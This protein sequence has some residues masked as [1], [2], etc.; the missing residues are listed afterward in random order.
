MKNTERPDWSNPIATLDDF[1]DQAVRIEQPFREFP[2]TEGRLH[3]VLGGT[4]MGKT[5]LLNVLPK[6][7]RLR[8]QAR[9]GQ[10]LV[11]TLIDYDASDLES[12]RAFLLRV[13]KRLREGLRE[14]GLCT[15]AE[16][17]FEPYFGD[18]PPADGFHEALK[19][20]LDQ[21]RQ[22]S[23]TKGRPLRDVR[24]VGL[25]DNAD[26]IAR[27]PWAFDLFYGLRD[28]YARKELVRHCLDLVLAGENWLARHFKNGAPWADGGCLFLCPMTPEAISVW[29][30]DASG[31]QL[32]PPLAQAVAVESGGHP[33]LMSYF[34]HEIRRQAEDRGWS[35]LPPDVTER[36]AGY[37]IQQHQDILDGWVR[38]LWQADS[39]DVL[40]TTYRLLVEA[41]DTGLEAT[42]VEDKLWKNLGVPT[43]GTQ[44]LERLVWQGIVSPVPDKPR[45]FAAKGVFSR[46]CQQRPVFEPPPESPPP[47]TL[48]A[49]PPV[50]ASVIEYDDFDLYLSAEGDHYRVRV[51]SRSAGEASDEFRN[52]ISRD[53][54]AA[55]WQN[56]TTQQERKR[57]VILPRPQLDS[58]PRNIEAV[59]QELF[60]AIFHGEVLACLR[61]AWG[62][63]T[64]E[65]FGL[66]IKLILEPPELHSL[67]W[68]L[69]YDDKSPLEFLALSRH[70]PLVRYMEQPTPVPTFK[71]IEQ[72]R[73]L[74]V[75]AAPE[76]YPV[77]NLDQEVQNMRVALKSLKEQHRLDY[78]IIQGRDANVSNLQ[79]ILLQKDYHVLEFGEIG[80]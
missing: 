39:P 30:K 27:Q 56:V 71:Q 23:S 42:A 28:L 52:P 12:P 21:A 61:S 50:S 70:T 16:R 59:G 68:E 29:L 57:D 43:N 35:N 73:L 9:R 74:F 37:F 60:H 45:H 8:E 79:R 78:D 10:H 75:V 55:M 19:F 49:R 72:L 44:T 3:A 40:W 69:L 1:R 66:R 7:L 13:V 46:Y 2:R 34:V 77:L 17:N 76:N 20:L 38:S 24:L 64:R 62:N 47:P 67:P 65:G 18:H 4:G 15:I 80:A 14:L 22:A 63:A 6:W 5:S 11:P 41:G 36:L 33:S 51:K 26:E 53:E 58:E 25:I 32:I 31:G 54:Q 48:T